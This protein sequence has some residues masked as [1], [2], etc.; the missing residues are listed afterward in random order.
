MEKK[1]GLISVFDKTGI[2]D[3][4]TQVSEWFNFIST[5]KT[6]KLLETSN[7]RVQ[8]VA[9]YTG[10][11][12]IL[13]GRVKTLHP[14]TMGGILG[15][16]DHRSEMEKMNIPPL[17]LIVVNLYPFQQVISQSHEL[18]EAIENIDIGGVTLLRA[19]AKNFK[20]VIVICSPDDYNSVSEAI[21]SDSISLE[22]RKELAKKAFLYTAEYDST[23]SQYF[24]EITND[25]FPPL[26]IQSFKNPQ[27]LR[28]GENWHQ[29]ARYYLQYSQKP[30]Y[31][32]LHGKK[33][34]LNNLVDYYAAIGLLS[35]HENPSCAIIKHTSP[36]GFACAGDI[37][38]AF[39]HAFAT[40]NLSAFGSAIG[41]NRPITEELSKKL[42]AMFV[43]A[44]IAPKYEDRAFEILTRKEKIVLCVFNNYE[45]PKQSIRLVPNGIL[46][47]PTDTRK[48]TEDDLSFVTKRKP[49]PKELKDLLFAWKVVKYVKSNSAVVSTD[50]R[51]L[52]IGM[53]QT[54]RIGAV[55]LA[56]KRAKDRSKGAVL[57]SDAFFPF[58]DSVE[59]VGKKSVT[60]II[61]PGGSIRDSESIEA[62]N[63]FDIAMVWSGIRCFLH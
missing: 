46:V 8:T 51:T 52:G 24:A 4:C 54:S 58:R 5:G 3:F 2:L 26:F 15:T 56:L 7:I 32:Q 28:Y 33:V 23:I 63:D 37:E 39:D 17:G 49:T 55:E 40:D 35:E 50:T 43:D 36:C 59:A 27:H 30:F 16:I 47:Q 57:A 1:L 9:N 21:I 34:S 61:A 20:E 29:E 25:P 19:A 10:Y 44:I 53:G 45:M 12:E 18:A 42:N 22:M 6:A 48:V 60:A 11:P 14:K 38:T 41:F 62:A 13:G 31:K